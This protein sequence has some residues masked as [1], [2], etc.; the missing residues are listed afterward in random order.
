MLIRTGGYV[1]FGTLPSVQHSDEWTSISVEVTE[2]VPVALTGGSP[3]RTYWTSTVRS[4]AFGG[5]T[6]DAP[7]QAVV[8]SGNFFFI[9][10]DALAEQVASAFDPPGV[11]YPE[12]QLGPVYRVQCNATLPADV[13]IELGGKVFSV[14]SEDLIYREFDGS[15]YSTFAPTVPLQGIELFFISAHFLRNVVAVFDFQRNEMC[16]AERIRDPTSS[17]PQPTAP[18]QVENGAPA[19]EPSWHIYGALC[20]CCLLMLESGGLRNWKV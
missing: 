11:Y 19:Y 4:V 9:V 12:G 8:D 18:V 10:P 1:G 7:Y 16:F 14:E 6:Y 5:E 20:L 17:S 2:S 3:Q 13:G 15:C